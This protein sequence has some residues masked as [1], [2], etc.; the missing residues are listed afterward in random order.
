M[1]VGALAALGGVGFLAFSDVEK[2]ASS[3]KIQSDVA[4]LNEAVTMYVAS[5]GSLSGVQ[6]PSQVLAK[7]KTQKDAASAK[8]SIV[9]VTGSM[10]DRRLVAEMQTVREAATTQPRA[11]WNEVKQRFEVRT[12]GVVGVKRFRLD[13]AL[14]D[15][16]IITE[17]RGD[18][19]Y[20]F[21]SSGGWVWDK[22]GNQS[23]PLS[24]AQ[25]APSSVQRTAFPDAP[26]VTT[27]PVFGA[28]IVSDPPVVMAARSAPSTVVEPVQSVDAPLTASEELAM[29]EMAYSDVA[30]A[31]AQ[32]VEAAAAPAPAPVVGDSTTTQQDTTQQ[33]G[34]LLA[35]TADTGTGGGGGL[36]SDGG[37]FSKLGGWL[38]MSGSTDGSGGDTTSTADG[39]ATDGTSTILERLPKPTVDKFGGGY[40]LSDFPMTVQVT[41]A[42]DYQG[43]GRLVYR[44]GWDAWQ[45][46]EGPVVV[47]ED[48][49]LSIQALPDDPLQY[50][51]SY[52]AVE[53]YYAAV[54]IFT[55][56]SEGDFQKVEGGPALVYSLTENGS[57]LSHGRPVIVVGDVVI[58]GGEANTLKFM[59]SQFSG[60]TAGVP[61]R[62]GDLLYHNGTTYDGTHATS[63]VLDIEVVFTEP[64]AAKELDVTL[65]LVNTIN[66]E[67]RDASADYVVLRE[68]NKVYPLELDGRLYDMTIQ[69]GETDAAGFSTPT[70]FHAYE[71]E[72]ARVAVMA[73]LTDKGPKPG[74]KKWG[75]WALK[76][77]EKWLQSRGY[78]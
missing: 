55:G 16:E 63:T 37:F 42:G 43:I 60:V 73:T 78:L 13:P 45:P 24:E 11:L 6:T 57:F 35:A 76:I 38:A 9:P 10:I 52:E 14:S 17:A 61:F 18:E 29:M 77:I 54:H 59:L 62:I 30:A 48:D 15:A 71:G 65:D 67:D 58:D 53:S 23:D 69:F 21:N 44:T 47:Q 22:A 8:T 7:L 3:A 64:M 27:P 19:F 36:L 33:S 39:G 41:N 40:L 75:D 70:E 51:E 20:A 4:T 49:R 1:V 28:A 56:V 31:E 25:V 26:V 74:G 66:S 72:T 12:S 2:G 68:P 50:R 46:Y 32:T 34:D 5:G